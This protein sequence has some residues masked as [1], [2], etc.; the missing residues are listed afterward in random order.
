V[1]YL[2]HENNQKTAPAAARGRQD[3]RKQTRYPRRRGGRK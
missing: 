2:I 3:N 1:G